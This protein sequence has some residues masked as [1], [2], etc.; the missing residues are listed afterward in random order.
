MPFDYNIFIGN[1]KK[2]EEEKHKKIFTLSDAKETAVRK[3]I[4]EMAT[5]EEYY[6]ISEVDKNIY[7]NELK[8]INNYEEGNMKMYLYCFLILRSI[9]YDITLVTPEL[10]KEHSKRIFHTFEQMHPELFIEFCK[11]IL[12]NIA[13]IFKTRTKEDYSEIDENEVY[14]EGELEQRKNLDISF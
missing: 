9:D 6:S 14:L 11:D 12:T 2:N 7:I 13:L 3:F 8:K 1:E 5:V 10:I 4:M